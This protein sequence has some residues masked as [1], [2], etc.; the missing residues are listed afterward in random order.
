LNLQLL[1][2]DLD[3]TLVDAFEDIWRGINVVFKRHDL[4]AVDFDRTRRAVGEGPRQLV[5]RLLPPED[6][7]RVDE[8]TRAYR[9]YYAENPSSSAH[10][11][12]GVAQTLTRLRAAGVRQA[13]LTNKPQN[14][15]RPV[16]ERL[17][18]ME[19]IDGLWGESEDATAKP[20]PDALLQV[21][22]FFRLLPEDC[23]LVGD[24]TPD[25]Q[26]TRAASIKFIGVTWG[27]LTKDELV[28]LGAAAT[29]ESMGELEDLVNQWKM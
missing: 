13:I 27:Q 22:R 25:A 2:Y 18:L 11:Y 28:S 8:I 15:A 21:P 29:I 5:E 19:L 10:L 7:G 17:G 4:P 9:A 14:V 26:V 24:G 12:P 16:C 1:I 6:A 3:G 20:H 23:A